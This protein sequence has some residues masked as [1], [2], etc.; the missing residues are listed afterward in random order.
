MCPFQLCV[1]GPIY[2]NDM[3]ASHAQPQRYQC[4]RSYPILPE[5]PLRPHKPTAHS[6]EDDDSSKQGNPPADEQRRLFI[7]ERPERRRIRVYGHSVQGITDKPRPSSSAEGRAGKRGASPFFVVRM[8]R[9]VVLDSL[10]VSYARLLADS[11]LKLKGPGFRYLIRRS[12]L[13]G[14]GK[15]RGASEQGDCD[16]SVDSTCRSPAR[17]MAL[18]LIETSRL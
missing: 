6:Q 10:C 4:E 2:Q 8:A 3:D 5:K 16:N 17:H 9:L 11:K 13:F 1:V 12:G 18:S 14:S 15:W 7:C